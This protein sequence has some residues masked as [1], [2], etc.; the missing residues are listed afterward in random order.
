MANVPLLDLHGNYKCS[1]DRSRLYTG[2]LEELLIPVVETVVFN[3]AGL[4]LLQKRGKKRDYAGEVFPFHGG[5][6]DD[7]DLIGAPGYEEIDWKRAAI[8]ELKGETS[9]NADPK[10][11]KH[12]GTYITTFGKDK[13]YAFAVF[14]GLHYE[15]KTHGPVVID[16]KE[17]E[18]LWWETVKDSKSF[19]DFIEGKGISRKIYSSVKEMSKR[20]ERK[21]HGPIWSRLYSKLKGKT[22]LYY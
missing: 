17:V 13:K 11:L 16:K 5:L 20:I 14:Y 15:Q 19:F 22:N 4:I 18:D 8:R 10:E 12:L 21:A 3:K 2:N 7:R 9:I 1:R 6:G